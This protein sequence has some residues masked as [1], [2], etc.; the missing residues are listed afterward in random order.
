[1]NDTATV[2]S[3]RECGREAWRPGG[4]G[5]AYCIFHSAAV[6]KKHAVFEEKW[7]EF[8]AEHRTPDGSLRELD[9]TGFIFPIPVSFHGARFSARTVF[10]N[11]MFHDSV[12][13]YEAEFREYVEFNGASF[14]HRTDFSYARFPGYAGFFQAFFS[15]LTQFYSA[16]FTGVADFREA[17]F[18]G[19]ASFAYTR[20]EEIGLFDH[21]DFIGA[22]LTN[23]SFGNCRFERVQYN[24]KPLEF[25]GFR[26]PARWWQVWKWRPRHRIPPTNFT[27]IETRDMLTAANRQ[28]TRD[29]EDEQFIAQVRVSSPIWHFFWSVT[30]DNGRSFWRFLFWCLAIVMFYSSIFTVAGARWFDHTELWTWITPVYYSLVTFSTLGFGDVHPRLSTA[31]GQFVVMTEVIL[32]YL[33]LGGLVAIFTNK[34]ARRA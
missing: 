15:G 34:L 5:K 7:E 30:S 13:F 17:S 2:C 23:S 10:S 14:L 25:Q 12:D 1:M 19:K 11:A 4:E 33:S 24:T 27:A 6:R 26:K 8:L 18:R 16:R 22:D 28:F 21:A 3:Y 31:L 32:G 9:C 20:F 29:I